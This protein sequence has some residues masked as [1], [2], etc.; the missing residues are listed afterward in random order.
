MMHTERLRSISKHDSAERGIVAASR[1]RN[2]AERSCVDVPR[3]SSRRGSRSTN[4]DLDIFVDRDCLCPSVPL[5][6]IP[7]VG[8]VEVCQAAE[9]VVELNVDCV[10]GDGVQNPV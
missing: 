9:V 2:L 3:A 8:V 1:D 10:E 5:V 7:C 4:V 6:E